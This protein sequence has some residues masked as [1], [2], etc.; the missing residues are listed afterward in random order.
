MSLASP[1]AERRKGPGKI[2]LPIVLA[3]GIVVGLG[4]SY[5]LPA[6]FGYWR[7]GPPGGPFR[8]PSEFQEILTL[9]TVLSTVS[10]ALLVALAI[11]YVKVYAETGARFALGLVIVLFALLIQAL[12]QYPLFLGL[13]G[14]FD[15][16]QGPYLSFADLFTI[17]AY[18]IFLYLSLE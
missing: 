6:P 13:S 1:A 10:V 8:G 7:F 15:E 2:W 14:P 3:V 9:H 4:L 17:T 12:V 18:A 11:I 5:Y 16:G